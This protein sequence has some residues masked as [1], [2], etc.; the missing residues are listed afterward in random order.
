MQNTSCVSE[1]IYAIQLNSYT[2]NVLKIV[3]PQTMKVARLTGMPENTI[4]AVCA[5]V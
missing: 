4:P 1:S 3:L 2:N 5:K